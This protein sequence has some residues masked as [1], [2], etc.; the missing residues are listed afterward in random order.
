MNH[1]ER[2]VSELASLFRMLQVMPDADSV[3]KVYQMLLAFCTTWRTIGFERAWLMRVDV[4]EA[5]VRGHLA[6]EQRLVS[7]DVDEA[8]RSQASFEALAKSVFDNYEQIDSSDVTLRARSFSVPLDW[9]R[10]AVVKTVHSGYPVL[11]DRKL[12]EY[13]TDPFFDF[14]GSTCYIAVPVKLSSGV[15][16]V[17][18]ADNG[19]TDRKIHIEDV[20]LVYSLAQQA[21]IAVERLVESADNKRKFR[22]LGKLQ[23]ILSNA[24]TP[25][26]LS[27][28]LTLA[29]SMVGRAAGGSGCFIK[30]LVRQKTLHVKAVDEY[31]VDAGETD[32]S[33]GE[34]FEEIL[35]RVAGAMK[36]IGGD[37]GHPLLN[38]VAAESVE[39]FYATPLAVLGE[40]LGALAVYVE[41]LDGRRRGPRLETR[42]RVFLD[43][44]AG[45]I[46]Q[47]LLAL[48]KTQLVERSDAMLDEVQ[49]NLVREKDTARAGR[50]AM[51]SLETLA[52]EVESLK[53]VIL[54]RAPDHE[55]IEKARV[56]IADLD[57]KMALHRSEL[58]ATRS[59][60]RMVDLFATV[61]EIVDEWKPKVSDLGVELSV[62]IPPDGPRLLMNRRSIEQAVRNIL[63][64]LGSCVRDGDRV[65]V[66]C[67]VTSDRA[68]VCIADTGEGLPGSLLSRLFMPFTEVDAGDEYR[69]ALSLAGDIIHRHAGEIMVKSSPSWRTILLITF[70]MAA[71]RDRRRSRSDRR[72]G[73]SDR[74]AEPAVQ[75]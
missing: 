18:A 74:R 5:S 29:L 59:P 3:G 33:I 44:C 2:T 56:L 71:N 35:D 62:H 30:D 47:R 55:R 14:F 17:L 10:S 7:N 72:R 12:S 40:G 8:Q 13:A 63:S 75:R 66:E 48:H 60:L 20:S 27:E 50:R 64:A 22:V 58:A 4:R 19:Q 54:S 41:G 73:R 15:A 53:S 16:A 21:A 36:P 69:S 23:D 6:A 42:N 26:A 11:A 9:H 65:M 28:G 25:E 37:R 52:A 45:I 31:S 68:V 39:F 34:S 43:V 46:A 61:G 67:S 24:R 32:I 70:P 49:A 38:E 57:E 51:E 1:T